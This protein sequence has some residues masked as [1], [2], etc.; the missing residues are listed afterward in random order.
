MSQAIG[1]TL[2]GAIREM[3]IRDVTPKYF[4]GLFLQA[5]PEFMP[6]GTQHDADEFMQMLLQDISATS[7]QNAR[8]IK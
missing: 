6:F 8:V 4:V 3:D 2:A 7:P 1:T 5:H